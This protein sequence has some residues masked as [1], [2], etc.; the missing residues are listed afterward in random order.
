M[1]LLLFLWHL[2]HKDS[3]TAHYVLHLLSVRTTQCCSGVTQGVDAF[4]LHTQLG[5]SPQ[6]CGAGLPAVSQCWMGDTQ[7]LAHLLQ[8]NLA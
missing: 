2:I 5:A 8:S 4:S 3:I 6:G 7:P 1:L